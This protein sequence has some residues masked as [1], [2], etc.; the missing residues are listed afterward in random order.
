MC[1]RKIKALKT[2]Y[3]TCFY[4]RITEYKTS[5]FI[6]IK[7]VFYMGRKHGIFSIPSENGVFIEDWGL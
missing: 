5:L 6:K 7:K 1:E 2:P 4:F 3:L